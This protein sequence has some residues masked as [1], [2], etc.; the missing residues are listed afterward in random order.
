[1]LAYFRST[2]SVQGL[3]YYYYRSPSLV[4]GL[5]FTVHGSWFWPRPPSAPKQILIGQC[6][7]LV[8]VAGS[9]NGSAL[10]EMATPSNYTCEFCFDQH[11]RLEE[12]R[13]FQSRALLARGIPKTATCCK[14]HRVAQLQIRNVDRLAEQTSSGFSRDHR[15]CETLDFFQNVI[16]E[17]ALAPACQP[18]ASLAI[19]TADLASFEYIDKC[20]CAD[21]IVSSSC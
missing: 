4:H 9:S 18:C 10:A 17:T 8:L 19:G 1:M 16:F 13:E 21:R 5:R 6:R 11:H 7:R 14:T 12:C 2:Q 20:S 3:Y 15:A